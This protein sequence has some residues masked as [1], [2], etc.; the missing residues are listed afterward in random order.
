MHP[1]ACYKYTES[2]NHKKKK[3]GHKLRLPPG[4]QQFHDNFSA[5]A[6]KK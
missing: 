2:P 5:R 3:A 4:M 6:I 1:L